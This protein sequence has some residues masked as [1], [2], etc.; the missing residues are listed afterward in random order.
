MNKQTQANKKQNK[1]TNKQ[2]NKQKIL[3]SGTIEFQSYYKFWCYSSSIQSWSWYLSRS[4]VVVLPGG[5]VVFVC[6]FSFCLSEAAAWSSPPSLGCGSLSL[7][8]VL[9]FRNQLCSPP[10]VL[11]WSLFFTVLVYWGLVSLPHPLSLGRGQ[12]SISWPPL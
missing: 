7:Y 9:R 4:L 12:W 1:Q 2:R 8:V 10:A 5:W 3:G 11:L 6:F